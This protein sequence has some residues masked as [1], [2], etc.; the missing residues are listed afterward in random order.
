MCSC[1]RPIGEE[2][3]QDWQ[4]A[5]V[6]LQDWRFAF[7]LMTDWRHSLCTCHLLDTIWMT[8]LCGNA[9]NEQVNCLCEAGQGKYHHSLLALLLNWSLLAWLVGRPSIF[10]LCSQ[11]REKL[12][13]KE[14]QFLLFYAV[15]PWLFG[16]NLSANKFEFL[17]VIVTSLSMFFFTKK[18]C[19]NHLNG[20]FVLHSHFCRFGVFM[21]S[22]Q[23][24]RI[25][26]MQCQNDSALV[27]I[28]K[29]IVCIL[30]CSRLICSFVA[31]LYGS[32][33]EVKPTAS[34]ALS[35][36]LLFLLVR[37][38]RRRDGL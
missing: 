5:I 22:R 28:S 36:K 33:K 21:W 6:V 8:G 13:R 7:G 1:F 30:N 4:L 29:T 34:S 2:R 19:R 18:E 12:C 9:E 17:P 16:V 32:E 27:V 38:V 3:N 11:I 20:I 31:G 26:N 24:S 25:D 15:A 14:G 37:L 10:L 23:E 35:T